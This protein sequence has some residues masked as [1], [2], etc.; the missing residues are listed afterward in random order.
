MAGKQPFCCKMTRAKCSGVRMRH[1][2]V[3]FQTRTCPATL[4]N[5]HFWFPVD[6]AAAKP[7]STLG[8]CSATVDPPS[9][10]QKSTNKQ[11]ETSIHPVQIKLSQPPPSSTTRRRPQHQSQIC[12]ILDIYESSRRHASMTLYLTGLPRL[13]ITGLYRSGLEG[14]SSNHRFGGNAIFGIRL[15][16]HDPCRNT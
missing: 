9:K 11:T 10:Q 6:C 16:Q 5:I 8:G 4:Q 14:T 2:G 13:K 3:R 12:M 7:V 15:M 1:G